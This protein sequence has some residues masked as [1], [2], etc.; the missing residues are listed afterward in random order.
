MGSVAAGEGEGVSLG[1][2]GRRGCRQV[3][4]RL[5]GKDRYLPELKRRRQLEAV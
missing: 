1:G 5:G 3:V 4:R 2:E